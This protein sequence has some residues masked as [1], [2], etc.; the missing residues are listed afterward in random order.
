MHLR[1]NAAGESADVRIGRPELFLGPALG[2][3]LRDRHRV[4]DRHIVELEH[5][6]HAAW[7]HSSD[8]RRSRL[9]IEQNAVLVE[10]D[11]GLTHEEPG[12]QGPGGIILVSDI[13]LGIHHFAS[14]F[15]SIW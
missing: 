7:A 10:V 8:L 5:G 2:H 13:K 12:P 1:R 3:G 4:P 11:A 15:Q 9:D 14:Q 6:H